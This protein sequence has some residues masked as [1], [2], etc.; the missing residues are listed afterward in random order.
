MSAA[1]LYKNG[2]VNLFKKKVDYL[3]DDIK[4]M[5]CTDQYVPDA[6]QHIYKSDVTAEVAG[7]GYVE[8]GKSLSNKS[9]IIEQ[10]VVRL[11]CDDVE[12]VDCTFIAKYAVI[13]NN[14]AEE[15]VLLGYIDFEKPIEFYNT[16][17]RVKFSDNGLLVV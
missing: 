9:I 2:V 1:Y 16:T 5:L 14:S 6:E 11:D 3:N 12:W 15:Q 4:I 10:G 7:E 17:C 13:Y 8:G